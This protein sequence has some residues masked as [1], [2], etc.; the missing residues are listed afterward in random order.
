M[1]GKGTE[2]DAGVNGERGRKGMTH[3]RVQEVIDAKGKLT[4]WEMLRCKI[5]YFTDGVALGTKEFVDQI[6]YAERHRFGAKRES[7]ARKMRHVD[8]EGLRTLRDLRVNRVG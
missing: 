3:E 8:G 4:Q 1:Y 5:R 7:G 2:V 6:L